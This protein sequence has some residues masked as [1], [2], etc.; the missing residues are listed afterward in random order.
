LKARLELIRDKFYEGKNVLFAEKYNVS[1]GTVR[2]W[3]AGKQVPNAKILTM[4][5]LNTNVNS[6][7]L[8]LG[9]GEMCCD[10]DKRQSDLHL[11]DVEE[12]LGVMIYSPGSEKLSADFIALAKKEL[13]RLLSENQKR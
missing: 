2:N 8:L 12:L 4:I 7:W 13:I 10:E 6:K 11:H 9:E 5:C 3:L 1:E